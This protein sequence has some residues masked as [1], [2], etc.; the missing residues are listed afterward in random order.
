MYYNVF[1]SSAGKADFITVAT[2]N[3][4]Y[5]IERLISKYK[6]IECSKTGFNLMHKL[7]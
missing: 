2:L 7:I 6:Y 3:E 5:F 4:N 1:V